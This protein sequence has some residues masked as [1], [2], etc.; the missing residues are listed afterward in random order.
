MRGGT[1]TQV[2]G[3]QGAPLTPR[4]QDL[5]EGIGT[6]PIGDPGAPAPKS[7]AVHVHR[8]QGLKYRPECI[9]DPIAGRDF[10]HRR[11]G[12]LPFLCFCR[13]HRLEYTIKELFG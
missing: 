6:L 4:A 10:I 3:V 9:R 8:Q 2:R 11:P 5:E 7:M 13:G 12:P 1:P